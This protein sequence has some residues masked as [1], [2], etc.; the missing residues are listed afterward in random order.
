MPS[1]AEALVLLLLIAMV[2]SLGITAIVI[3]VLMIIKKSDWTAAKY[4]WMALKIFL[5][6]VF[7]ITVLVF[8]LVGNS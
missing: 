5:I 8:W 3:A 6:S 4:I 1:V 7:S 2:I